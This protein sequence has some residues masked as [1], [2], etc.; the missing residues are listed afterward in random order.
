MP[1]QFV[2]GQRQRIYGSRDRRD[3]TYKLSDMR[4]EPGRRTNPYISLKARN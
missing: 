4:A 3:V 2:S 1:R